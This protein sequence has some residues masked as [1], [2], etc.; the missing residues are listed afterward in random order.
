MQTVTTTERRGR[1]RPPRGTPKAPRMQTFSFSL[2]QEGADLI[3]QLASRLGL[4][5]SAV[6]EHAAQ[7]LAERQANAA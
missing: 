1:G 5:K 3:E 2:S 4:T 7:V 6:V